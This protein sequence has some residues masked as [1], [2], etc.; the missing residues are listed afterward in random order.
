[1]KALFEVAP[2]YYDVNVVNETR[3]QTYQ[4]LAKL[5]G[6]VG[7]DEEEMLKLLWI[8]DKPAADGSLNTGNGVT[9]EL[10]VLVKS[11][12]YPICLILEWWQLLHERILQLWIM[13]ATSESS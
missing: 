3:N 8:N 12:Y 1:M 13:L 4:R 5:G 10:K 2:S 11:S 7:I 9:N 6:T